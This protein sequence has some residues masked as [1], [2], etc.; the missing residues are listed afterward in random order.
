MTNTIQSAAD[1]IYFGYGSNLELTHLTELCRQNGIDPAGIEPIG[2]AAIPDMHLAFDYCSTR[3]QGGVLNIV[4]AIGARVSGY[5]F[6][7]SDPVWQLFDQKEGHPNFYRRTDVQVLT[8]GGD[9]HRATTYVV[10]PHRVVGFVAPS[11]AYLEIC[12]KGREALGIELGTLF[13]AA[14]GEM[15]LL[16]ALFCY[17]TLMR[18]EQRFASVARRGLSCALLTQIQGTL[19]DHGAYPGLTLNGGGTVPGDFFRSADIAQLLPELDRV[20]GFVGYG[21]PDNLFDRVL[22]DVHV[23]DGRVREAWAYVVRAA[24]PVLLHPQDWRARH[25]RA[26]LF[27][28]SVIEAHLAAAPDLF[29][30][31]TAD[32]YHFSNIPSNQWEQ[33]SMAELHD[34]LA[35][36]LLSEREIAQ[37]SG[38][39]TA[40]AD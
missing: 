40:L 5:L 23:G 30:R 10:A 26:D 20:E 25:G 38:L 31:L 3:W 4:P 22:V 11:E 29:D 17:G 14:K 15:H 7:L 13:A 37:S 6:K 16:D 2:P 9:L 27:R 18:G 34:N 39:W 35:G 8:R 32:A 33:I 12:R 28:A 19:H 1:R 21:H 24:S 36:G